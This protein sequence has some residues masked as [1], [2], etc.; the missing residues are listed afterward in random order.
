M[1]MN[2]LGAW[3]GSTD[4]VTDRGEMRDL[5]DD[6]VGQGDGRDLC[7]LGVNGGDGCVLN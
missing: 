6:G 5:K 2:P 4:G 3:L 7:E 1:G